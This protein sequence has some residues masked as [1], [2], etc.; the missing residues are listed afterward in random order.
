MSLG[1]IARM[2]ERAPST[3]SREY[4]G[5]ERNLIVTALGVPSSSGISDVRHVAPCANWCPGLNALS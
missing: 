2:L 3:I 5:I 4:V 1:H